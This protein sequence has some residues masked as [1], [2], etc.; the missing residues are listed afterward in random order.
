MLFRS[1]EGQPLHTAM[2]NLVRALIDEGH[3]TY[4]K[5][6]QAAKKGLGDMWDKVAPHFKAAWDYVKNIQPGLSIKSVD[7][8]L[9]DVI[10]KPKTEAEARPENKNTVDTILARAGREMPEDKPPVPTVQQLK[11]TLAK[12]T[13]SME[14]VKSY[15]KK[16]AEWALDA[17]S[18]EEP[19]MRKLRAAI[20]SE[21]PE[22]EANELITRLSLSQ[23]N[24]NYGVADIAMQEGGL[25]Y[26][27]DSTKFKTAKSKANLKELNRLDRKSTRLNSSH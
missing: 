18:A 5:A 22:D 9:A 2:T 7:G 23:N 25:K 15:P 27:A 3:N 6:L 24:H 14:D 16:I 8:T 13:P 10:G 19:L 1:V 17:L 4:V 20:R 11:S 21:L 26:D 12:N